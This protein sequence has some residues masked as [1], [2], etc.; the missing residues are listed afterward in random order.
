MSYRET[1]RTVLKTP[2]TSWGWA[3]TF[4]VYYMFMHQLL[5]LQHVHFQENPSLH[6][7][8]N[9]PVGLK[10]DQL[11]QK[12]LF[13]LLEYFR[14]LRGNKKIHLIPFHNQTFKEISFYRLLFTAVLFLFSFMF[15]LVNVL[16]R[17]LF[18]THWTAMQEF[19]RC[20]LSPTPLRDLEVQPAEGSLP[21]QSTQWRQT[22]MHHA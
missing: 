12:N 11:R 2:F 20:P 9:T 8:P 13:A 22:A 16:V 14:T 3:S 10:Q 19:S 18:Y 5:Q 7:Q 1:G 6:R 4:W 21:A 17:I 15:T